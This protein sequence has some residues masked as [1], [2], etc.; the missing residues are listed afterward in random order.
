MQERAILRSA[1]SQDIAKST[2]RVVELQDGMVMDGADPISAA[3]GQLFERH[4]A[5]AWLCG[6]ASIRTLGISL[7]HVWT[8]CLP[9]RHVGAAQAIP[10]PGC[11]L[12]TRWLIVR[13][14]QLATPNDSDIGLEMRELLKSGKF[15]AV[16]L[17]GHVDEFMR[18]SFFALYFSRALI[19]AK[20]ATHQV[21][22]R[23]LAEQAHRL[24]HQIEPSAIRADALDLT[25]TEREIMN[26]VGMGKSNWEIAQIVG[27]SEWTV[28]THLRNIFRKLDV[29]SRASAVQSV[30]GDRISV[31]KLNK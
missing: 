7:E 24:V 12:L 11:P 28:K 19:Q 22:M 21:T 13:T 14:P 20:I 27:R 23:R 4:E 1:Y 6:T 8:H 2:Y 18:I 25:R 29:T 3:L 10:D 17:H 31:S 26:W 30:S 5:S 15:R 16:S 9:Q